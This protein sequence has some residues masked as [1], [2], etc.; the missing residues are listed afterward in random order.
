VGSSDPESSSPASSPPNSSLDLR[1][2]VDYIDKLLL[3]SEKED[4]EMK[5]KRGER[6]YA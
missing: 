6:E 5:K 1:D 3:Y 4:R 2:V